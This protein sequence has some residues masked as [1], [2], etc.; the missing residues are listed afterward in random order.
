MSNINNPGHIIRIPLFISFS[1]AMGIFIGATLFG[2]NPPTGSLA[3][4]FIRLREVLGLIEKEYVDTINLTS[5]TNYGISKMLEKL[6]PHTSFIPASELEIAK[7]PLEGDFEG[8]GIEFLILADTICVVTPLS[9]GPSEAVGIKAGDK[10]IQVDGKNVAGVKISNKEV[11]HSLRGKRGTKVKLS[12]LR[13][14]YPGLIDFTVFR[15]KIPTHSV[16]ASY[17]IEPETGYIKV[18][19]FSATTYTEFREHLSKLKKSGAKRLVLDLRDNPGGYMDRATKMAD[20]FLPPEKLIVYT[21]GKEKKYNQEVYS[22]RKGMF[23]DGPVIVL[24]N[25]GTASASEIVAGALQDNDRAIIVGRRSF[26]KG[27]VQMPIALKDGSEIRLTI[28]RYYTPSG[29]SIQ[30]PYNSDNLAYY[31]ELEDRYQRGEYFKPDTM[32]SDQLKYQ[33]SLGRAVYGGGG[34]MPDYFI[35]LDTISNSRFIINLFNKNILREYSLLYV[36][37]QRKMLE[38]MSFQAYDKYFEVGQDMVDELLKMAKQNGIDP[39]GKA[40]ERHK[41][42]VKTLIKAFI[43]RII[44]YDEGFYPIF[45]RQDELLLKSLQLFPEAEKLQHAVQQKDKILQPI[46]KNVS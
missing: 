46:E 9:G 10:I 4:N 44:W 23:E 22:T 38:R 2:E 12:I 15:D 21:K 33:T 35:P 31:N 17:M 40:S 20:E 18:S 42:V 5:I 6:D 11:F 27:L 13:K 36:G 8:I 7:A 14:D 39:I 1:L 45:N 16:D 29:R 37:K 19:R 26:G 25:E 34:I 30:K 24:I 28:S 41:F 32:L 43:A 3:T